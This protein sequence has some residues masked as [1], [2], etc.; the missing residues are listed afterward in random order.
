MTSRNALLWVLGGAG[1]LWLASKSGTAGVVQDVTNTW[2]SGVDTVQAAISG[3]ASVQQG[4]VWV[5][6]INQAE[7]Q[8]GIPAN[9][10]ARMAYQ[11]SSF[12]PA[13][14]DGTEDSSAGALGILQL[15]PQYFSTVRVPVPFSP[16]DTVAQIQQAAQLLASLY[17]HYQDW[18]LAVGAYND[19]QGNMD[20]YVAGTRAL[21]QQTLNYVAQVLADV[22]I[23]GATIP[24]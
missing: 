17:Q 20:A 13:Y 11:E 12:R 2:E 18:G 3:W 15:M 10:L 4:P 5:P 21:P 19:G 7:N 22:P 8:F 16:A 1:L 9:L 6:V 24:A 14:I 23:A